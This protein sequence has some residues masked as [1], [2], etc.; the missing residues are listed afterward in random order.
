MVILP[1]G[2][3]TLA[4]F[5]SMLDYARCTTYEKKPIILFNYNNYYTPIIN[6][7]KGMHDSNF[8]SKED[9]KSFDIVTDLKG[10]EIELD[11][12]EGEE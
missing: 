3:G 6:M 1:G 8:C 12:L 11:K 5:T 4:E 7:L 2:I 9:L 10:L